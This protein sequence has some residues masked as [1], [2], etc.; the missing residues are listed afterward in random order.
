MCRTMTDSQRRRSLVRR[1]TPV[2]TACLLLALAGCER[3][4]LD[5]QMEELCKKD[6]GVSVY[7]KVTLPASEFSN[8][9][10]PLAKYATGAPSLADR[11]GPEYRYVETRVVVAGRPNADPSRGE[12]K[13]LRFHQ[14]IFR[15]S[16]GKLLG[17]SVSYGRSGG[18]WY[19]FGFHPSSASCPVPA[20]SAVNEILVKG[21]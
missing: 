5:R 10:Q 17:E 2:A 20:K 21:E 11:L 12:G 6:G 18:D 16:D 4:A 1:M 3:Y 8:V 7:E 15:R 19:T 13:L 14:A 9:G